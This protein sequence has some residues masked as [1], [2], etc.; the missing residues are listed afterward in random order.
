MLPS[1]K[2]QPD[3]R[4]FLS[5]VVRFV[6]MQ[7]LYHPFICFYM[8]VVVVVVVFFVCLLLLLLFVVVVVVVVVVPFFSFFLFWSM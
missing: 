6:D 4:R 5:Q 8:C 3:N 7:N 1:L 2:L